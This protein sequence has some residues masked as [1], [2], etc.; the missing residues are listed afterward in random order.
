M[1]LGVVVIEYILLFMVLFVVLFDEGML[2]FYC[3][4]V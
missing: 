2:D 3:V 4:I 1:V